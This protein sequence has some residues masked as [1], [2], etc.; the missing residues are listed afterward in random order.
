[1]YARHRLQWPVVLAASPAL[2]FVPPAQWSIALLQAIACCPAVHS[3]L[4]LLAE[5]AELRIAQSPLT[6]TK[7]ALVVSAMKLKRS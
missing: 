7:K 1:M 5:M 3:S 2:S 6:A 4:S